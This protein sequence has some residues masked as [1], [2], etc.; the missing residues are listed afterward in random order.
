MIFIPTNALL[1]H[2]HTEQWNEWHYFFL[3]T[4][5]V[6]PRLPVVLVCCPRTLN[7]YCKPTHSRWGTYER[8]SDTSVST[9]LLQSLQVFSKFVIKRICKKLRIFPIYNVSLSI[10]KPFWDFILCWVLKDSNNTLEFFGSKFSST[11][12]QDTR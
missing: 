8:M 11:I 5:T 2:L 7:C 12:R 10:E 9:N 4:P 1:K 3:L 6:L